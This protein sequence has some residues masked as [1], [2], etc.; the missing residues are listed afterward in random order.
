MTERSQERDAYVVMAGLSLIWGYNWV[1]IRVATLDGSPLLVAT[2]RTAIGAASL[3][4]VIAIRRQLRPTPFVPTL[5]LGLLQTAAFTLFQTVAVSL[6]GAGKV[7]VLAYTMPFWA[8]LF[9]WPFLHERIDGI[10]W[11]ALALA[12][13][14]L[15]FVA[16]PFNAGTAVGD[17]LAVLAGV[18]WGA[19]VV[20]ARRLQ[21]RDRLELLPLTAW[22]TL[23]G[24]IPMFVLSFF[25]PE[26]VRWTGSFIGAIVYLG[27][28]QGIA[29]TMWL[30]VI[31]RLP[32][33]VAGL[34]SLATPV[35][36][37]GCAALQ[38]HEIP[39]HAELVGMALIIGALALNL[40]PAAAAALRS[41]SPQSP[42]SLH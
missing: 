21:L 29:W 24:F 23:W 33:G 8:T 9:A 18:A 31:A 16:A 28:A 2:L 13:V 25:F 27:L 4:A 40:V 34:A 22:Q 38:L 14:G 12:G 26:H 39:N 7:A 32:A 19:S 6:G 15:G 37:V 42:A 41:R 35:I 10:R 20:W 11:C 36:G 17:V 3:L 30:Y 5:V 1:V